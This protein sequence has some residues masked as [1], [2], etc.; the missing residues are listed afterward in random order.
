M[1][2][3]FEEFPK[4]FMKKGGINKKPKSPRPPRPQPEGGYQ[5]IESSIDESN[6]PQ[7]T[8]SNWSSKPVNFKDIEKAIYEVN[9]IKEQYIVGMIYGMRIVYNKSLPDDYWMLDSTSTFTCGKNVYR[10]IKEHMTKEQ[11]KTLME[12]PSVGLKQKDFKDE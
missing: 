6:P 11:Q 1:T 8:Y 5:P 4:D 7:G 9:Q 10:I 12:F 2:K 3:E